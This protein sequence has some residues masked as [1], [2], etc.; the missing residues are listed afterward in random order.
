MRVKVMEALALGKAVVAS[1]L[2][3][4]G[5]AV[6]TGDQVLLAETDEEFVTAAVTLLE[7][8]SRRAALARRAQ[9]WAASNLGWEHPLAAFEA[10][11]TSLLPS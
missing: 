1:P 10:L 6:S 11:Y 9:A 5:L 2:A 4:E 8:T 7:V 3:V